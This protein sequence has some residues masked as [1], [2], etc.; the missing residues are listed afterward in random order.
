MPPLIWLPQR[1]STVLGLLKGF[2]GGFSSIKMALITLVPSGLVLVG[3]RRSLRASENGR[4]ID[5]WRSRRASDFGNLKQISLSGIRTM[6]K[7]NGVVSRVG[8]KL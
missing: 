2:L 6:E 7:P 1:Q 4:H 3:P 8:F 5:L